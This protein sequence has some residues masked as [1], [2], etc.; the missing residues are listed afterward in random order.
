VGRLHFIPERTSIIMR[1][2]L[3]AIALALAV[4]TPAAASAQTSNPFDGKW[5]GTYTLKNTDGTDR[6]PSAIIFNLVQKGKELSGTAGPADEQQKVVGTVAGN[7]ATFDVV[8]PKGAPFKFSLT[9]VKGR[10]QGD[11][12]RDQNGTIREAKVDAAKVAAEKK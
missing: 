10:L 12:T 2:T 3:A 7:K 4:F 8:M 1:I 5:E 11:M 6:P 9:I